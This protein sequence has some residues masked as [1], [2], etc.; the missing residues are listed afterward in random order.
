MTNTPYKFT[1]YAVRWDDPSPEGGLALFLDRA[2]A[3]SM[4]VK[5]HGIVFG[6]IEIPLNDHSYHEIGTDG[7]NI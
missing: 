3:M 7:T 5:K 2:R 6:L 1:A 4:C